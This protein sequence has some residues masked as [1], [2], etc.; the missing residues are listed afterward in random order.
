MNTGAVWRAAF[1]AMSGSGIETY[2]ELMVPRMFEPWGRLLVDQLEITADEPVLDV[3]CGPGS[4]ARLAAAR[5]GSGGRVVGYDL[6]AAM[7]AAARAKPPGTAV[8]LSNTA[9]GRL[10]ACR[11]KMASSMS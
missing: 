6:S 2:D 5:V 1:G 7:L 10:T 9:R 3:A 11:S 8:Q 4:V